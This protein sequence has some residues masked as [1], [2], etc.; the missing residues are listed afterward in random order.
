MSNALDVCP[1]MCTFFQCQTFQLQ[2]WVSAQRSK[3]LMKIHIS[4]VAST[5]FIRTRETPFKC[6]EV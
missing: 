5:H 1:R 2:L 4:K 6:R 3:V